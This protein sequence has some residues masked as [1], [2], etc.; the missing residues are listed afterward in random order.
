[1][2]AAHGGRIAV[3]GG[4]ADV[5]VLS[6]AGSSQVI[7]PGSV[8]FPKLKGAPAWGGGQVFHPSAPLA[9]IRARA[10]EGQ[11]SFTDGADPAAAAAAARAADVAVVFATQ[12]SSEGM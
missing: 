1:P 8:T 10:G 4:H 2:L 12:W 6:G 3:I 7:P 5:G 9:A 11:V